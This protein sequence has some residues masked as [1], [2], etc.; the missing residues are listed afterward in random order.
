LCE[1]SLYIVGRLKDVMQIGGANYHPVDIESVLQDIPGVRPGRIVAI[2]IRKPSIG[3]DSL[4]ILAEPRAH[5][6]EPQLRDRIQEKVRQHIGLSVGRVVFLAKGSLPLTTSGKVMR[7]R[8]AELL[9][10][11]EFSS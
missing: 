8:C 11:A 10:G 7:T 9:L 6:N 5:A 2:A 3:T 1:G 4:V